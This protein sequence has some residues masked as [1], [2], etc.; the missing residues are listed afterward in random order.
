MV[1]GYLVLTAVMSIVCLTLYGIDKWRAARGLRRIPER[2]LQLAALCGGWPGAWTGQ[3][4]FR[5]KTQKLRFRAVLAFISLFHVALIGWW[6]V[7]R[8]GY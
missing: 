5:H 2:T 7:D 1:K 6:M 4:F 3:E 8:L